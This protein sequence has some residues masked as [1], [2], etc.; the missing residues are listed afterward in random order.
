MQLLTTRTSRSA[1]SSRGDSFKRRFWRR[2]RY[3]PWARGS[4]GG[5]ARRLRGPIFPATIM[6]SRLC[7]CRGYGSGRAE[8]SRHWSWRAWACQA[9]FRSRRGP[10]Y[11]RSPASSPRAS[12]ADC[13]PRRRRS[14]TWWSDGIPGCASDAL[15][16]SCACAAS[17]RR[18]EGTSLCTY[19]EGMCLLF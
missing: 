1:T 11:S 14:C 16:S 4:V 8:T 9:R 10:D 12:P 19:L 15:P 17:D 3:P 5:R 13:D 6:A 7:W 18:H 2:S